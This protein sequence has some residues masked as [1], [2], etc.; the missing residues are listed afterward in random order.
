ML[1]LPRSSSS[2]ILF[3]IIVV[4]CLSPLSSGYLSQN[5]PSCTVYIAQDGNNSN[6]GSYD[7]P[8][9]S[10]NYAIQK[11][12]CINVNQ[13]K[14]TLIIC[15]KSGNYT[16]QTT[17]FQAVYGIDSLI[18][19]GINND[20][21]VLLNS[22]I[23]EPPVDST[24]NDTFQLT[25]VSL[26]CSDLSVTNRTTSFFPILQLSEIKFKERA[27]LSANHIY[28]S[29][30]SVSGTLSKD[31]HITTKTH[32]NNAS[33][34]IGSLEI[35]NLRW[36]FVSLN[37]IFLASLGIL[38]ITNS[39]FINSF[40]PIVSSAQDFSLDVFI[41][42]VS[43]TNNQ[44]NFTQSSLFSFPQNTTI[45][46]KDSSFNCNNGSLPIYPPP[47]SSALSINISNISVPPTCPISCPFTGTYLVDSVFACSPCPVGSYSLDNFT[48][49][50]CPVS[51]EVVENH[52]SICPTNTYSSDNTGCKPCPPFSSQPKSGMDHCLC[53]TN[54]AVND[55]NITLCNDHFWGIIVSA[56]YL[57]VFVFIILFW[58]N[59]NK[60]LQ[61][62]ELED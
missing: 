19:R 27:W 30:S 55:S 20:G 15:L 39:Y 6:D 3:C 43:I 49:S 24:L 60:N 40:G 48:C 11:G 22:F 1:H 47:L 16:S 51:Y 45:T 46:I 62:E 10:I 58:R 31:F 53:F 8:W 12:K 5:V 57:F 4:V 21:E 56:V 32:I 14:C 42:N 38:R 29:N 61:Y 50:A 28:I 34:D 44:W 36:N 7:H 33:V 37:G 26:S 23:I 35:D 41:S 25:L 13:S 9:Q 17:A 59:K 18:L 52:C 54:V 2:S